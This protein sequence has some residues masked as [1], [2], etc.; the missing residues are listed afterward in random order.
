M[1]DTESSD[2]QTAVAVCCQVLDR[3]DSGA[4]QVESP[5]AVHRR[6]PGQRNLEDLQMGQGAGG[7]NYAPQKTDLDLCAESG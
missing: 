2:E 4:E 6:N 5:T 7:P 3:T 1:W